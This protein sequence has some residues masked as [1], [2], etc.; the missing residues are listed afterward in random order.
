MYRA[1]PFS[2]TTNK[3]IEGVLLEM[4]LLTTNLKKLAFNYFAAIFTKKYINL[5][6]KKTCILPNKN[7]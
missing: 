3:D 7:S 5:R 4:L 1:Q 2:I 6:I